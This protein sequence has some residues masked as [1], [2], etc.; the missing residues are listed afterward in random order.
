[1]AKS[2]SVGNA[3]RNGLAA[4]LYA[5]AGVFGP[6]E[7]LLGTYGFLRVT[8]NESDSS[9]LD[10][11]LGET[12]QLAEN[13]YKLYPVGIVLSPVIEACFAMIQRAPIDV[14]AISDVAITGHP[15]LRERTDRVHP[16]S[17]REAQVSAQH[18]VAVVLTRGKAGLA[19]FSDACTAEASLRP[20]REKVRFV[21]DASYAVESAVVTVQL[22]GGQ[23]LSERVESA[24]GSSASPL[25]D[26]DLEQKLRDLVE[27][28]GSK[29]DAA[30]LSEAVWSIEEADDAGAVMELAAH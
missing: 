5:Q 25:T 18:A 7:P 15:L 27:Y 8:G 4:A 17:G 22:R 12:W 2:V 29:A 16:T 10:G 23:T 28:S 19:D 3:A 6:A 26:A 14:S 11:A 1:M 9:R 20:L 21:D 30:R 13:T 24:R